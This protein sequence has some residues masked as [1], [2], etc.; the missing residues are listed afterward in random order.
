ALAARES[1][2]AAPKDARNLRLLAEILCDLHQPDE[3]LPFSESALKQ[4]PDDPASLRTRAR[5]LL[6]LDDLAGAKEVLK[7][8]ADSETPGDI[9][10]YGRALLDL[11]QIKEAHKQFTKARSDS[12]SERCDQLLALE[13]KLLAFDEGKEKPAAEQ[14][15]DLGELCSIQG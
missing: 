8:L 5:C 15:A 1:V 6:A 4:A 2:K 12:L 7:T 11:G 9:I 3:A 10:A 13:A 14:L